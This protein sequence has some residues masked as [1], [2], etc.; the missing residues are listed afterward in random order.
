LLQRNPM[1]KQHL[2]L[3]PIEQYTID[4]TIMLRRKH[5]LKQSDIGKIINT[6]TSFIGNVENYKNP[7]K[8]NLKHINALANYFDITPKYFLP[9][10]PLSKEDEFI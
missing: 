9:E 8:Y 4:V 7:A 5:N 1:A 3:D 10:K 2:L 6:K